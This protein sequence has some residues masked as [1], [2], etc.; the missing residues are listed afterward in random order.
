MPSAKIVAQ[1]PAGTFSPLSSFGHASLAAPAAA[2]KW[3]PADSA[4]PTAYSATS[5]ARGATNF[6]QRWINRI[7]PSP[8]IADEKLKCDELPKYTITASIKLVS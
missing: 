1:K 3:F 4:E 8:K 5:A 7:E 2:L 6:L